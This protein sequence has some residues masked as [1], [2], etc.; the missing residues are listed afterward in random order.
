[1]TTSDTATPKEPVTAPPPQRRSYLRRA[2]LVL[3]AFEYRDVDVSLAEL[4]RRTELPKPT[5]YRIANELTQC[6][7][8]ERSGAGYQLGV[9]VFML[10]ERVPRH[11]SL[12]DLATPFLED[13]YEATHENV[14]LGVLHGTQILF[15]A[16]VTGHRSSDVLLRVG[17]TLPA[18]STSCGKIL[19]AH[20]PREVVEQVIDEGLTRLTPNTT[21]M[22]GMFWQQL[23]KAARDGYSVNL[24]ETHRG[25]VSVAAPVTDADH[26]VVAAISVTGRAGRFRVDRVAP[27]VRTAAL[28]L[29]RELERIQISQR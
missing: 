16:R 1:M 9:R 3:E 28:G 18:Y 8:L 20:A 14:N 12:R 5:V 4:T 25:T 23:R 24:E 27:A 21:V 7:L 19:L 6:G 22:P 2:L 26:H 29:S 15:L 17:D 10:G 11:T 13:L